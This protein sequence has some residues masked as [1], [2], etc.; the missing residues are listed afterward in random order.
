MATSR[1]ATPEGQVPAKS[2]WARFLDATIYNAKV[3][4]I[5]GITKGMVT[6]FDMSVDA[7]FD[8]KATLEYPEQK[9]EIADR[10]R[11]AHELLLEPG[12]GLICISCNLCAEACPVDC[13]EVTFQMDGKTRVL[14]QYAVD[15]SKCLFCDLCVEAC[16]TFCLIMTKKYEY[17]DYSRWEDSTFFISREKGIE[18]EATRDEFRNMML[19][20]YS[21]KYSEVTNYFSEREVKALASPAEARELAE[22][23]FD[24]SELAMI[25]ETGISFKPR[26]RETAE[27]R[28]HYA[29]LKA[30]S[31][32]PA[33]SAKT[34]AASG[35]AMDYGALGREQYEQWAADTRKASELTPDDRKSKAAFIALQKKNQAAGATPDGGATAAAPAA[36]QAAPVAI[37]VVLDYGTL[38]RERYE[39]WAGDDRKA[40]ELGPDERKE[41]AAF[42]ALKRKNDATVAEAGATGIGMSTAAATP[43]A[44]P[45]APAVAP[46][47]S[48][49]DDYG[50]LGREK[51]EFWLA[52]TRRA[53]ELSGEERKEKAESVA[54]KRRRGD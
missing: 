5:N 13:I 23:A 35:P 38:G 27:E 49:N 53:S 18:R 15:L 10:W 8:G 17:S 34:A 9:K 22:T 32:T 12:G 24:Q 50:S 30:K 52:D 21:P 29:A 40:S 41:K 46:A 54:I 47:E 14:D 11:G 33:P 20:G 1:Q 26:K 39:F 7:W 45:A 4:P 25:P 6:T 31:A 51:Y 44:A 28:A 36:A 37:N 16:P 48:A 42:I 19:R 43:A 3:N 2:A